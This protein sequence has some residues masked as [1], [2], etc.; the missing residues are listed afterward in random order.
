MHLHLK[1]ILF[2]IINKLNALIKSTFILVTTS[3]Y[4]HIVHPIL[5]NDGVNLASR[6][7]HNDNTTAASLADVM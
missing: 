7:K 5:I 3:P 6:N 1:C 4:C 2:I